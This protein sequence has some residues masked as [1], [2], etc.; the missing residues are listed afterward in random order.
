MCEDLTHIHTH[1]YDHPTDFFSAVF[2]L[3]SYI[4]IP[5]PNLVLQIY[6]Y[7]YLLDVSS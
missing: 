6:L 4:F 2:P 1:P 3:N 5:S 7:R